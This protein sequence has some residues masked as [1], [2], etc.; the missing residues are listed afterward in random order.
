MLEN[1]TNI[2][3]HDCAHSRE[4]F[5][6]LQQLRCF[7]CPTNPETVNGG[8]STNHLTEGALGVC[9]DNMYTDQVT[10]TTDSNFLLPGALSYI[11]SR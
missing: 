3:T 6:F 4:P 10:N 9:K 8:L 1:T 11:C 2:R 5:R 7:V